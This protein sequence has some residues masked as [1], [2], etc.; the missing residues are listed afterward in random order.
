MGI[1]GPQGERGEQGPRGSVGKVLPWSDRI[2]Y[3]GELVT[4]GGACWQAINDTAK[5]PNTAGKD[6][7]VIA[8]AGAPG[9]SFTVRGTFD[10][11]HAY[12]QLDVVTLDHSWFVARKD[13]P[14][15]CPGPGWQ[16][17]P[18][19]KKGEKGLPGE[20]GAKG[21]PGKP[22]AHWIGVKLDGFDVV[23]VMSDGTIGPRFSLAPMFEQFEAE[24]QLR[25]H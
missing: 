18:V 13:D 15:A 11:Q 1:Q 23:A 14:G 5:E 12:R 24:R 20:R 10:P 4:H 6:W 7:Q 22:A 21:E 16:S 3:A 2:F 8:A 25:D 9:V 17:G 19:G